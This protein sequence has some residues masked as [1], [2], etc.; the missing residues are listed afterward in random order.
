MEKLYRMATIILN[1]RLN[2]VHR[3]ELKLFIQAQKKMFERVDWKY[4]KLRGRKKP[5]A[6]P[7]P[8]P[9]NLDDKIMQSVE[10]NNFSDVYLDL[11]L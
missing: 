4:P 9:F 10:V 2:I 6:P 11:T 7:I 3:L 1:K 5:K 8:K